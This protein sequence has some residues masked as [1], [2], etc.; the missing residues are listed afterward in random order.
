ML[1]DDGDG[2]AQDRTRALGYFRAAAAGGAGEAFHNIGAAYAGGRGVKPDLAEGL[3]W[4][5]LAGKNGASASAEQALR[6]Q[7]GSKGGEETIA[8]GEKRAQEIE[9]E[10]AGR[11]VVEWL[12]PPAPLIPLPTVAP[13][14]ESK[15]IETRSSATPGAK[16][17]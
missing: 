12:P 13:K 1:L 14:A 15:G 6:T 3:G 7:L 5:I 2:V 9:R 16:Q 8:R 4:L 11:K 10:L 17:R